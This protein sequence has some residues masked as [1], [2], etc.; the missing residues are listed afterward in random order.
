MKQLALIGFIL[1]F[2]YSFGQLSEDLI[3]KDAVTVLS[4]NNMSLF[5]KVSLDELIQYDFMVD[6][7]QEL[8]DGST[9]GKSIK[10][11]G[12]D[13]TQKLNVF[14]G[15]T[16][17]YEISGFTFGFTDKAQLFTVF[18]DFERNASTYKDVEIYSSYFN[19]LILKGNAGLL[20]R[21]E[22]LQERIAN[23]SDSIWYA[24]GNEYYWRRLTGKRMRR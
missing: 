5:Q 20:I 16:Y 15:K 13:L 11:A 21:V 14:Y 24:R 1:S 22:P 8:F 2:N 4:I 23:V 3:P 17:D 19:Q 9:A 7:Q 12:I 10:D 18:D 6:I